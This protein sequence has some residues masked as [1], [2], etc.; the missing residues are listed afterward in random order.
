MY[1]VYLNGVM[2]AQKIT[3]I[4]GPFDATID[5]T[6]G[7]SAGLLIAPGDLVEVKVIHSRPDDGDFNARLQYVL[8]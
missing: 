2:M 7:N 3:S 8:V 5:L 4:A 6:S 1:K